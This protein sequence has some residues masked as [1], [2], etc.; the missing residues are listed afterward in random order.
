MKRKFVDVPSDMLEEF[1]DASALADLGELHGSDWD[2]LLESRRVL[3]LG[4]AGAGKT[5]ECREQHNA[6]WAAGEACFYLELSQLAVT[7]LEDMLSPEERGRLEAWRNSQTEIATF[8]LDSFDEL[9]LTLGSFEQALKRLASAVAGQ[10]GRTA[11]I[12]TSRPIPIDQALFRQLLPIPIIA[13]GAE[14]FADAVMKRG[15]QQPKT[16]PTTDWRT[17]ALVPLDDDQIREMA[18]RQGV[19]DANALMADIRSRN[20]EQFARRPQDLIEL[21]ADWRDHRRIRTHYEQVESNIRVKLAARTTRPERV[22]LS[23]ERAIDGASRLALAA[24]LTRRLSLRHSAEADRGAGPM[25]ALD[26]AR[27][28]PDWSPDERSTLLERAM[29]VFASYGRVRFHHRSVMEF[30]AAL[31]VRTLMTRGMPTK[32]VKRLLFAA[33]PQGTSV[34]KPSMRPVAGWMAQ[35]D[36]SIYQEVKQRDPSALLNFGDPESLG[37]G[38]RTAALRA[39][40]HRYGSGGRRGLEVP[41]IQVWRFASPD[42]GAVIRELWA[43]GIANDEVREILLEVIAA[44]KVTLCAD[45]AHG[46]AIEGTAPADERIA[47]LKALSQL[48]DARIGSLIDSM[49]DQAIS[50]P[51]EVV[52]WTM[53]KL[54][55]G[56]VSIESVARLLG[57]MT[58][59]ENSDSLFDL[60]WQ[61]SRI[62]THSTWSS[63]ALED[64]RSQ[65]TGLVSAE[66]SA[67][68]ETPHIRTSRQFVVP[69]LAAICWR[70]I[71]A[72]ALNTEVLRSSALALRLLDDDHADHEITRKLRRALND[73]GPSERRAI[74]LADD[75]LMQGLVPKTD[76][77]ERFGRCAFMGAV[78][79]N[80]NLD[81]HWVIAMLDD[82]AIAP[83]QRA[84]MLEAATYLWDGTG[85]R[86]VYLET[87]RPSIDDLPALQDTLNSHIRRASE[88]EFRKAKTESARDER[89]TR[90]NDADARASWIKFW[91]DV[92]E[93][94]AAAF[95][96]ERVAHTRWNLWRAMDG[97]DQSQSPSWNRPFIEEHFGKEIADRLQKSLMV[98]WR[99]DHPSLPRERSEADRN[100]TLVRWR[101]GLAGITA[102]AEDAN[103]AKKLSADEARLAARY[104]PLQLNG[105]PAWLESLAAYHDSAV[106]DVLGNELDADLSEPNRSGWYSLVLQNIAHAPTT[107]AV[108]FLSRIEEWLANNLDAYIKDGNKDAAADRVARVI[109]VLVKHGNDS[110]RSRLCATAKTQL[111]KGTDGPFGRIWLPLLLRLDVDAGINALTETLSSLPVEPRGQAI[112][113]FGSLLDEHYSELQIHLAGYALNPQQLLRMVRLA[114]KYVRPVDDAVHLGVYSP[115]DRDRAEDVRRA[116][117]HSLLNSKGREGWDA[118]VA[119]AADPLF[120][121][122]RDRIIALAEERSAE[123]LDLPAAREEAVAAL[124]SGLELPP[125]TRDD[126]FSLLT[127]RLDDLEDSLLRDD[128]PRAAWERIDEEWVMRQVIAREL[129][130]AARELYTVDQEAVTADNKETD[131]RLR[132]PY[133]QQATIELKIG[134]KWS[135]AELKRALKEQLVG[136]YMAAANSRAGCMVVTTA[137]ARSWKDPETGQALD[138]QQLIDMLNQYGAKLQEEAGWNLR[139]FV[140]GLDL[141]PRRHPTDGR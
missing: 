113:C 141:R 101:L 20:A 103:W 64:L 95:S 60:S 59:D 137:S 13:E 57:A 63:Q 134:E 76:A 86:R 3:I 106:G 83:D 96:D 65:L 40:V 100:T 55:P 8:F 52:R 32:A 118:K 22:S 10:L 72:H 139:I 54:F 88:A 38:Q 121:D 90:R 105:F 31:R 41:P 107:V 114:Y 9:K 92:N 79:L 138:F 27:V 25:G 15:K 128:S 47:A 28:L 116:I 117:L 124:D 109:N 81:V 108:H 48:G 42:L 93:N 36:D 102:E 140:K 44:G 120:A 82:R 80:P 85:D 19:G 131:I 123:E 21:C 119:L 39:F 7:S 35:F 74:F 17:V 133:D 37:I 126:M 129:R 43:R 26:P 29:F 115:D 51:D 46:V 110:V 14:G 61:L 12:L 11:I 16:S 87:L 58:V 132:S 34:V 71:Q 91:R 127:D 56:H 130:H 5:Y 33:T 111:A 24:L 97:V 77:A 2:N 136:K 4:E 69:V 112:T 75:S 23:L 62:I 6:K 98:A 50:W 70:Q 68:A 78:D 73:L 89:R 135:A 125:A 49:S 53:T 45:L 94:P 1:E 18:T 66:L 84:L 104:A 99:N 30:L 122:I 67:S